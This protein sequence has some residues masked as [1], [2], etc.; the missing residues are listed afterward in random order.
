MALGLYAEKA[1]LIELA[2]S[3]PFLKLVLDPPLKP[4]TITLAAAMKTPTQLKLN[5]TEN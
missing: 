4:N 1:C 5:R 2:P 3:L